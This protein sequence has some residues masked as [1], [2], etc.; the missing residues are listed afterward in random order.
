MIGISRLRMA[1]PATPARSTGSLAGLSTL[2]TRVWLGD[3]R[4]GWTLVGRVGR[5]P[6]TSALVGVAIG[7]AGGL[8]RHRRAGSVGGGSA[9]GSGSTISC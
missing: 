4:R 8:R 1:G 6:I 9:D 2:R 5:I 7:R 3:R